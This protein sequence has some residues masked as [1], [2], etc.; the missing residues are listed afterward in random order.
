MVRGIVPDHIPGMVR[1]NLIREDG[2]KDVA[3]FALQ[4]GEVLIGEV[5]QRQLGVLP[6]Q[7]IMLLSPN[8]ARTIAGFIPKMQVF[9]V[10]G[11]FSVGMVQFDAGLL[12]APIED[13]QKFAGAG[14]RVS[15]VE[16][17]VQDP[18]R[19]GKYQVPV[20]NVASRFAPSPLDVSVSTWEQ[21]N[22]DFFQALQVE[23]VTMFIILSLIVLVA[24]F[25]I[26]SGQMML[27]GDKLSDIAI[28]RTMGATERQIRNIFFYN[29]MLLGGMGTL[30]GVAVGMLGVWNMGHIVDG[31]KAMFGVNLFP[32]DVYFL[33]ELPSRLAWGDLAS[34]VAMAL[35][36]TILASLYPAWR[37]A[38]F[39]P[40]ELLRR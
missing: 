9:K 33:S 35:V 31:V 21:G 14:T 5:L 34:V 12:L 26:I 23:R 13:V 22:K 8:G 3:S 7:G 16:V 2:G 25:N 17:K 40:V 19:V 4:P 10:A 28:L 30:G 32:G 1:K 24:A 29:G 20:T 39:N 27:V 11:I 6:G 37:A 36:L 15:A 18:A 38:K